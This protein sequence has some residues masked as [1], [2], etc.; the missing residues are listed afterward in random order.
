MPRGPDDEHAARLSAFGR[1][2]AV[3]QE[4]WPSAGRERRARRRA[5]GGR[6]S[7]VPGYSATVVELVLGALARPLVRDDRG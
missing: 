5:S 2:M 7:V 6:L 3:G 4:G 1:S